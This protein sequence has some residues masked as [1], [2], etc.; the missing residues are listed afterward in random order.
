V[1]MSLQTIAETIG[2]APPGSSATV[3]GWSVD[4]RTIQPNDCFFALRGPLHDGHDY[5]ASVLERG[6]AVAIVEKPVAAEGLQLHVA[7][8]TDALQALG[9]EAR[10]MWGGIVVGVTGSA[11]KTSTK[12]VIAS[13]LATSFPTG[14]TVGN[15]NNHLGLPLSILRLP[16]ESKAAVLE[17]GMNHAGEI[18]ELAEIAL[19]D[20]GVVTNVGWAHTENF[21][22]GI[23]GVSRAKSE[24][25]QMLPR[26]GTAVL[27]ADDDRVK[28]FARFHAGRSVL[29]GFSKDAEIHA[30]A[31]SL[32]PEGARFRTLG[33]EFESP[34]AGKHAVSNVLAGIAVAHV[35]G[36]APEKLRDAVRTLSPGKMRGERSVRNGV[37]VINDCYNANPEAMRS[38]LELLRATPGSR[39]I[40]VLGEMLELGREAEVLHRKTGRFA[41]EQGIDAVIGIRG[42]GRWMVDEAM[43]AGLSGSAA[44]FFDTPEEAGKFLRDYLKTGDVVLFKGS[45]GVHVERALEA[46]FANDCAGAAK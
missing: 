1:I 10:K 11:G 17:M 13:L 43:A 35:M 28:E 31:V 7:N 41:A 45:R 22:D 8:T 23:E 30:E 46:A 12:D 20:I 18:R 37:T 9:R 26:E 6:A 29:F 15:L 3:T 19:P 34:L 25:I 14:R 44:L 40:A 27:N 24:L 42:A 5:V 33:V 39:R 38:M 32:T 21:P 36:I 2:L 4:S 16:G